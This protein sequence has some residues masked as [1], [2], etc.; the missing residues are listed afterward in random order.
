[1]DKK[2]KIEIDG[3]QG[4]KKVDIRL[5]LINGFHCFRLVAIDK[6][7]EETSVVEIDNDGTVHRCVEDLN[8]LWK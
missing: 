5:K 8:T 7:G 4:K 1:M 6:K 2:L 3:R